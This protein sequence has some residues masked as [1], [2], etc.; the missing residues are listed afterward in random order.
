MA[1][2]SP[3]AR[4]QVLQAICHDGPIAVSGDSMEPTLYTGDRIR[5]RIDP[6][7]SVG[8]VIVFV[9]GDN[10]TVVHRL[11]AHLGSTYVSLGDNRRALDPLIEA[12]CVVGVAEAII[13]GDKQKPVLATIGFARVSLFRRAMLGVIYGLGLRLR[14]RKTTPVNKTESEVRDVAT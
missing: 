5:V 6:S 7:P 3:A 8:E 9:D 14:H 13:S 1:V 11:V 12:A 4:A 10:Q 2:V